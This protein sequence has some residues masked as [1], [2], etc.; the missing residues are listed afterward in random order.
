[1]VSPYKSASWTAS[2]TLNLNFR[3]GTIAQSFANFFVENFQQPLFLA[4]FI[5]Q[6]VYIDHYQVE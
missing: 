3:T 4:C 5:M 2:L 6:D 1:M